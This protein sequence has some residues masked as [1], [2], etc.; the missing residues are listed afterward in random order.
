[1]HVPPSSS[2]RSRIDPKPTPG[3]GSGGRPTPV[4]ATSIRRASGSRRRDTAQERAEL[5]RTA[6]VTASTTIRYAATSTAAGRG[7]T[8]SSASTD[9]VSRSRPP[10]LVGQLVL[11]GP[12]SQR[13]DQAELVE[14][15]RSQAVDQSTYLRDIGAR[16]FRELVQQGA[17][18]AAGPRPTGPGRSP[19]RSRAS[20]ATARDRRAGRGA[21]GA[22]LPPVRS[23]GAA[24][25]AAARG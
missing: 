6:F 14:D 24:G 10:D 19:D 12:L 7:S 5:C 11:L 2:A 21:P 15:R 3:A 20:R 17:P 23:R 18:P 1:M 13:R 22:A 9:Q 8:S 4:S 25:T 16:L